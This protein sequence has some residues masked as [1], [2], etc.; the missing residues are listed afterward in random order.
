MTTDRTETVAD[1][2]VLCPGTLS[3]KPTNSHGSDERTI[4]IKQITGKS[5]FSTIIKSSTMVQSTTSIVVKQ[6]DNGNF[7]DISEHYTSS[8][9]GEIVGGVLGALAIIG[10]IV[11]AIILKLRKTRAAVK[12]S[13]A[14]EISNGTSPMYKDKQRKK[15]P[16]NKTVNRIYENEML[17]SGR[18]IPVRKTEIKIGNEQERKNP[19]YVN[20]V[21]MTNNMTSP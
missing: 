5:S 21:I 15:P 6:K 11:L 19:N 14:D 7:T 3:Y 16:N 8:N 17:H 12:R 9:I 1:S 4:S 2:A 13:Y 18:P 20:T 10:V